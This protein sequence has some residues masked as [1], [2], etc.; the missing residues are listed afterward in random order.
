ML[1]K[2]GRGRGILQAPNDT[3]N[4]GG[5]LTAVT[6]CC[7]NRVESLPAP[8]M[9]AP[10]YRFCTSRPCGH[11]GWLVLLLIKVSDV[12]TNPGPTTTHKKSPDL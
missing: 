10:I 2:D 4:S 8:T 6:N 1:V 9:R 12:E 5:A 11:A 7:T 3:A